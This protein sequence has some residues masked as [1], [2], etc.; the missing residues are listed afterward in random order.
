M[1]EGSHASQLAHKYNVCVPLKST[2][3]ALV[4]LMTKLSH[5]STISLGFSQK[6]RLAQKSS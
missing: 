3:L 5:S 1:R 4:C 2:L 6:M